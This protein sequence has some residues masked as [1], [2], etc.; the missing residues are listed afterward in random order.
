[1]NKYVLMTACLLAV[2]CTKVDTNAPSIA[3][4][5]GPAKPQGG[6]DDS[7]LTVDHAGQAVHNAKECPALEGKFQNRRGGIVEIGRDEKGNLVGF[8]NEKIVVNGQIQYSQDNKT[9]MVASCVK[10]TVV[11]S[12]IEAD[13]SKSVSTLKPNENGYT[14]ETDSKTALSKT[15]YTRL[16]DVVETAPAPAP[17]PDAVPDSMG[18]RPL[19]E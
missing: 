19:L 10:N 16:Q 14:I 1:M 11:F 13:G 4:Q 9:S 5:P 6:G 3:K 7:G 2:A 8:D 12:R 15:E 18:E 17:A